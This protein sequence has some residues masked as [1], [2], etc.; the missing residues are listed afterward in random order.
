[1]F[2]YD[3]ISSPIFLYL[4]LFFS[5]LTFGSFF[6]VV[7]LRVPVGK[8][9]I[10]PPSHCYNCQRRLNA[11][12]L[13][14]FFGYWI[15]RGRCKGCGIEISPLYPLGELLTGIL[16]M[17]LP[18][19]LGW[20]WELVIG[21]LFV[22]MLMIITISDLRYMIIP[23]RVLL[24]FVLIFL[25]LRYFIGELSYLDYLIGGASGF[26][27]FLLITVLS[28]GRMGGGDIK[29]MGVIGLVIGWKG[30]ALTT[31]IGSILGTVVT[32][33]LILVRITKRENP[34]PFGPYLAVG[35]LL[36]YFYGSDIWEWYLGL[37]H[38][39]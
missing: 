34:L 26:L 27:L 38:L 31:L 10:S 15:R 35:A 7:G 32:L 33:L 8:S 11:I 3:L 13:I 36:S 12:D 16:F 39:G 6:N 4:L 20:S 24:P 9:I 2:N 25:A 29:L 30:V 17:I 14:P 28:R 1:M 18:L 23:D 5:G 21:Y 19:I 22:S 37:M